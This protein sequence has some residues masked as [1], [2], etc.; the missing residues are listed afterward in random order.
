MGYW[1]INAETLARSRFTVS[2]LAEATACLLLL[3]KG[4]AAHP[5]EQTWFDAHLPAY[6]ARLAA[7][8]VTARL[9]RAALSERWIADFLVPTPSGAAEATF[10]EE[11]RQV[12][13]TPPETVH[14]DLEVSLGGPLPAELDRPDLADHAADLLDWVWRETVLPTWPRRRR[15][16]EADIVARTEKLAQGGWVAALDD[17][18]PGLRWLGDGRLQINTHDNPPKE[19]SDAQLWFVPVIPR[20]AAWVS[21]HLPYRYAV[22]YPCTGPLLGEAR[23]PRALGTLLGSARAAVLVLLD[24]P[25]STTQLVA[26]T[27]QGLG[28][29]GR[30]LKVLLDA[31]L[32][33]RRRAGRSVLYWRTELGEALVTGRHARA[34]E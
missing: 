30:H 22:V 6:R 17:M 13:A 34:P 16:L 8:P 28:S 19:L 29:V 20:A 32:V 10:D 18:R 25:K 33:R 2:A 9:L 31:G 26:L 5:A 21:W 12:R 3:A 1:Q 24:T 7:D 4:S 15:I 14:A 27:G 23:A 11:L